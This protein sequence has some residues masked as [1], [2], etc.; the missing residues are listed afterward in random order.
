MTL[1]KIV[2][3]SAAVIVLLV[4]SFFIGTLY[5]PYGGVSKYGELMESQ[6]AVAPE[7]VGLEPSPAPRGAEFDSERMI[8]YNAYISLETTDINGV[9]AKIRDLAENYGGYVA[10]SSRS[11]YGVQATADV[12]I[13]VPKDKFHAAVQ[14]IESY[15]KVLD[16]RTTSED[17]TEQY[18]DLKARLE[19]LE[20]Q[21][22]RLQEILDMAKT[23]EEVLEVER[24]L[25]RVRGEIE[26]F[27][28]QINY[29]ER[30]VA[31]SVIAV[32]LIEPSP[33][34]TPSGVDWG[35]TLEI[36]I[37]GFSAV[38]RGLIILTVSL[39]PI[40]IIAVL[41]Y[42]VYKRRKQK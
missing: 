8:I 4:A 29:L 39:L 24:E 41:V 23:V 11:T 6:P 13:R 27:Q 2:V 22:K 30:S 33:P 21:E 26:R 19:N 17:V 28:G 5:S 40:A 34:F 35:E 18:I 3:I 32:S 16:E 20:S 31:M 10:G 15:G 37:S 9:L 38:L 25:E 12:T 14:E 1:K 36:A 7:L 42:Y